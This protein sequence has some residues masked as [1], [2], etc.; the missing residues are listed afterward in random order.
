[1]DQRLPV[2][3]I[4]G[5]LGLAAFA[6]AIISG[7]SAGASAPDILSRAIVS[8]LACYALGGLVA[9]AMNVAVRENIQQFE[10]AH[11]FKA[12]TTSTQPTT[13]PTSTSA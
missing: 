12:S 7:L 8:L 9:T 5:C 10:R 2:R 6:V 1:M 3:V 13:S 4:G 11:P